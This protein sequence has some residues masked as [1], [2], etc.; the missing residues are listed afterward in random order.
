MN[1]TKTILVVDDEHV[2]QNLLKQIL[3]KEGYRVL[4]AS[5]GQMAVQKVRDVHP[6][7]V[8][9]DMRM[10]GIDGAE[11]MKQIKAIDPKIEIVMITGYGTK[12][13]A[14]QVMKLGAYDYLAKPFDIQRVRDIIKKCFELHDL[15]HEVT[16][17]RE[18]LAKKQSGLSRRKTA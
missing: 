18:D 6:D 16:R 2:I 1:Q 4:T 7:L 13:L 3:V 11:T 8:L 9:L 14:L 15:S 10:P 17:L 5:N 12:K